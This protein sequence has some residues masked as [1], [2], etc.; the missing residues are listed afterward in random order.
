MH[1]FI[2][3][4]LGKLNSAFIAQA[5]PNEMENLMD[6]NEPQHARPPHKLRI[7]HDFAFSD[8]AGCMNRSAPARLLT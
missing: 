7:D 8:K 2:G 4:Q 6:N 3:Q 5:H 1:V